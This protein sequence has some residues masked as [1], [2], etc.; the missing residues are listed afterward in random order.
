MGQSFICARLQQALVVLGLALMAAQSA[1][2]AV[3]AEPFK[4]P[5]IVITHDAADP[6]NA[7]LWAGQAAT[8]TS[9]WPQE[10]ALVVVPADARVPLPPQASDLPVVS[11]Q[12]LPH[13]VREGLQRHGHERRIVRVHGHRSADEEGG[14]QGPPLVAAEPLV[15]LGDNG[16]GLKLSASP[17]AAPHRWPLALYGHDACRSDPPMMDVR[18]RAVLIRR[19]QCPYVD[20]I[21]H[22][23]GHGAAAVLF[24]NNDLALNRVGGACGECSSAALVALPKAQGEALWRAVQIAQEKGRTLEVSI[25][26]EPA[27][28]S[29]VR[30]GAD[31][32]VSEVGAIPYPFNHLLQNPI[33]PFQSLAME[34]V[35]LMHEQRQHSQRAAEVQSGRLRVLTLFDDRLAADPQWSGQRARSEVLLPMA[36]LQA[37][38]A[39]W[40]LTLACQVPAGA[41]PLKSLCPP[42]DY[43]THLNLCASPAS[44]RCEMEVARWI[45]PYWSGG[46]WQHDATPLLGLLKRVAASAPKDAQGRARLVFEFHSIQPYRVSAALRLMMPHARG[47]PDRRVGLTRDGAS[48]DA[49]PR[50]AVPLLLP[51]GPMTDGRYAQRQPEV[52]I[53]VPEGASRVTLAVW[54]TGHG[55]AD[56]QKCAEF[57]NTVHSFSIDGRQAH[58]LSQPEAGT[59]L[60]CWGRVGQGVVPNQGGTWVYGR[61]GWCPGEPVHLREIDISADVAA[62]RAAQATSMARG[63]SAGRSTPGPWP[64][65]TVRL[66]HAS[67]V[68]GV[69]HHPPARGPDGREPDARLDLT[70]YAVFR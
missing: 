51:G 8:R 13:K 16:I 44:A 50:D 40:D 15:G 18:G 14:T 25:A 53:Q 70:V 12:A 65:V 39:A 55:F 63:P 60:G 7:L 36:W 56:A 45:T 30:V 49:P 28:A 67:T 61:N 17:Q 29:A 6:L 33:D 59:D 43:I 68:G 31:G 42:W 35:H 23:I 54:A 46:Q 21:R 52:L 32:S 11:L 5:A 24:V 26:S 3:A 2:Q 34:A 58:V 27:L 22:A 47:E 62:A 1:R 37:R 9:A 48:V 20:K 4:G 19:G 41:V 57:C 66:R 69:D 64:A 38:S 10:V